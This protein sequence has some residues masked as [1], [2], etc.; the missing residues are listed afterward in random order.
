MVAKNGISR[1]L[2]KV[3]TG[4]H[5]DLKKVLNL[6]IAVLMIVPIAYFAYITLALTMNSTGLEAYFE[7][8]PITTVMFIVSLM[9]LIVAYVLAFRKKV[10]LSNRV[11]LV[12]VFGVLTII[13]LLVGNL[14]SVV[15]G[16]IVLYL[17]K[18][19]ESIPEQ[20]IAW[21]SLAVLVG[22]API[23]LICTWL[24]LTIGLK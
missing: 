20:R 12:V 17:S 7:Q 1:F 11:T 15:L 13:Q 2:N 14:I 18:S 19:I 10:L 22:S 23:Y 8:S 4:L 3:I 16:L 5:Y 21:Q 6:Y 9:D 24:L